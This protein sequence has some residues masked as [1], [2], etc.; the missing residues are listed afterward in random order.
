MKTIALNSQNQALAELQKSIENKD[1]LVLLIGKTGL[2]KSFLLERLWE[3]EFRKIKIQENAKQSLF[4]EDELREFER[5]NDINLSKEHSN[6]TNLNEISNINSTNFSENSS[7]LNSNFSE[8]SSKNSSNSDEISSN[9]NTNLNFLKQN[10]K[11]QIFLFSK[12]FFDENAFVMS[13][14]ENIFQGENPQK[15]KSQNFELLCDKFKQ[16]A[17]TNYIFLL[18]EVG[19][20]EESLLEKVR[21]LSDMPNVAFILA[22]HKKQEILQKEHF[23]SRIFKEIWL[24]SLSTKELNHYTKGKF[25]LDFKNTHLKRLLH[26]SGSNLRL[27]DKALGTFCDLSAFYAKSRPKPHKHLLEM[28]LFYHGLLR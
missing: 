7:F 9:F 20:Y 28:S 16:N 5:L 12:P 15:P 1:K 3:M 19:M 13:L 22:L 6:D 4:G 18:D 25:T 11:Q 27:V 24:K 23:S 26:A 10:S 21:L 8:I 14:F 17:D 2:G